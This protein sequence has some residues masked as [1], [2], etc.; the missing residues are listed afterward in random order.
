MVIALQYP[1]FF[2]TFGRSMQ[3]SLQITDTWGRFCFNLFHWSVYH[4]YIIIRFYAFVLL[5]KSAYCMVI[6]IVTSIFRFS[7]ILKPLVTL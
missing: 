3:P 1:F 7:G 4:T 5:Y 2:G 6:I